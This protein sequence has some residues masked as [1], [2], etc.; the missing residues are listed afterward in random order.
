MITLYVI[1]FTSEV[2]T[3][4]TWSLTVGALGRFITKNYYQPIQINRVTTTSEDDFQLK[5]TTS[6]ADGRARKL[7]HLAYTLIHNPNLKELRRRDKQEHSTTASGF[8]QQF[9]SPVSVA[10]NSIFDVV[11]E[12]K[13][14]PK[15]EFL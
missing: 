5:F 10:S 8:T 6:T 11:N 12:E 3:V 7:W 2:E 9:L 1:V 14:K 13:N 4:V 15:I